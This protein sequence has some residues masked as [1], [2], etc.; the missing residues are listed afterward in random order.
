ML[1]KIGLITLEL[2][3]VVLE[4]NFIKAFMKLFLKGM[5]RGAMLGRLSFPLL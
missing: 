1:R 3:R 2:I 5:L 4:L